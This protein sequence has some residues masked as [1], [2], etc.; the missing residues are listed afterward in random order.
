LKKCLSFDN[1]RNGFGQNNNIGKMVLEKCVAS[2]NGLYNYGFR[3]Y[4]GELLMKNS[5]GNNGN[6]SI[7]TKN[8]K[9]KNS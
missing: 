4:D 9:F 3:A 5:I 2:G 1:S 6:D 7:I 8:V